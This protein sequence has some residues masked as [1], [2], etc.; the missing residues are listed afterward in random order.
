[1]REEDGENEGEEEKDRGE[2][3]RNL[4]EDIGGLSPKNILRHPTAKGRAKAF[5]FRA[6][7]QDDKHHEHRVKD[8][9]AKE[10]VNQQG[11]LGRAI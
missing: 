2:P 11:H 8:V 4:G 1:V 3:A 9:D 6:L 10:N 5:A 7:H